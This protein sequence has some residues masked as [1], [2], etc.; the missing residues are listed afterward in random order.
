VNAAYA[1]VALPLAG[2]IILLFGGRVLREPL[3]GWLA[4]IMAAGSFVCTV[5]VWVSLLGRSTSSRA[6]EKNIFTWMPVGA[7]HVNFGLQ[8][9]PLSV[10]WCL[11]V[12]GV[13][14]LI[15]LYSIGYMH[16]DPSFS[17]F[18]FLLNAFVFS[19]IVLVL[20][21]N[22][23][24]SFFGWEGVG[25]CS[26]GLVGFWFE[27]ESAAV[28]AKKA[29]VTNRIGDFGFMIALFLMFQHFGSF[30][31]ST[32]LA[33]LAGGSAILPN[34][35]A[36]GLALMLFLGAVGKSAQ[37]PLYMWLPDAMEGP[38]PVSALIHAAT[39]VTAGVY[40]V[41]RAAPI[42]H[43]S[44]SA[45]WVISIIGAATALLAATIAC[46]QNDI[47]RVLAYSTVSQ[48]GYMFLGEG[49]GDYQAGIYH[50]VMHA[51]FKA[52]LFLGSG[53]VIHAMHDEQDM[54]RM[55]GLRKYLPITFPTFIIGYLALAAIP[56]FDGFWSKDE[57]LAAAW[58]KSPAL[59]VVGVITAF[60]TAYYMSRLI[61]LTFWGEARWESHA[62]AH[63][64]AGDTGHGE[65]AG[66]PHEA[67]VTM[68][69]PLVI[70]AVASV[71]GWLI[72]A[73]FGGLDFMDKWL[74]PVFPTTI[75]ASVH[76][77]TGT[78]WLIGLV[79]TVAAI[80]GLIAG[81]G[82]W[83]T[84][85]DR[86]ALEPAVLGHAWYI[87][88]GIA[89]VVSGP[90]TGLATAF[91]F[92]VDARW[93]DGVGRGISSGVASSGRA[94]RR[95]QTGYVRNYALGIGIGAAAVLFYVSLRAG[96]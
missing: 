72:N 93:M 82:L 10:L 36:T 70:L 37:I 24:F 15:T 42:I 76:V 80:A 78:K 53:A 30:N 23:L 64:A 41:A 46:G 50:T 32:V 28:A 65:H 52:L 45:G 9:D 91:S 51:F 67:P 63:G 61:R 89:H 1:I 21:N 19:M 29:F 88:E 75:A 14:S 95:V 2:A 5:I 39:M 74:A 26:Y 68:T 60:L 8:L 44:S 16:G 34:A 22:F 57:I 92:V 17:R 59:W 25:F 94:L 3:S 79:A 84:A 38:T 35:F 48:L 6:V 18:F 13:G 86:P 49:T 4:T 31:Y 56:P 71:V 11:F 47:K 7:L 73:P 55:G 87:D 40:L 20:A 81:L 54:K 96:S 77:A 12:T 62:S 85:V 66:E 58:H 90:L 33:P 27:R 69:L 83:R 43:F